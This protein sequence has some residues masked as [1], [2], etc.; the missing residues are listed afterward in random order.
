MGNLESGLDNEEVSGFFNL[1]E[2][3][4]EE[5]MLE[6]E[7]Y[8]GS[9]SRS[10]C[11]F[12]FNVSSWPIITLIKFYDSLFFSYSMTSKLVSIAFL[13]LSLVSSLSALL[14]NIA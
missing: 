9:Y 1:W 2:F 7:W 14:N 3:D 13:Y 10:K 4:K 12:V 6:D 8:S 5:S 11:L